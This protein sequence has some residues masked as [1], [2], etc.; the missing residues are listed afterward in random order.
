MADTQ[1]TVLMLGNERLADT[2]TMEECDFFG[3]RMVLLRAVELGTEAAKTVS[4]IE[5]LVLEQTEVVE[6]D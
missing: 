4:P 1:T 5:G 3:D 2:D 6:L